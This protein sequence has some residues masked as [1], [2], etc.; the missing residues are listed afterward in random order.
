MNQRK[1][2]LSYTQKT[3]RKKVE[4]KQGREIFQREAYFSVIYLTKGKKNQLFSQKNYV[5]NYNLNSVSHF[6]FTS[7]Y[8][9]CFPPNK[10]MPSDDIFFCDNKPTSP[11]F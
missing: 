7:I 1:A 6:D 2:K 3:A 9:S 5:Y 8:P 10:I 11:V 4:K